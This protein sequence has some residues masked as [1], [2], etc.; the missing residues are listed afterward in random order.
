MLQDLEVCRFKIQGQDAG[1]GC[2]VKIVAESGFAVRIQGQVAWSSCRVRH[3][4]WS[5]C[6]F[7]HK[8]R[9]EGQEG[10]SVWL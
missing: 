6:M 4:A 7:S 2:K 1:S 9:L 8:V 5:S 3:V 10:C